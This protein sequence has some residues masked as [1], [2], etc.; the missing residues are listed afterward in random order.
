MAMRGHGRVAPAAKLN[1]L[2]SMLISACVCVCV[3]VCVCVFVCVYLRVYLCVCVLCM[4][5]QIHAGVLALDVDW[6]CT[7]ALRGLPRELGH[8]CMSAHTQ[9]TYGKQTHT[10]TWRELGPASGSKSS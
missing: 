9:I 7:L 1:V 8:T 3:W 6:A 2:P 5:L 10:A 4:Y